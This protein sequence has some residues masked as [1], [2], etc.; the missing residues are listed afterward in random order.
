MQRI[1]ILMSD[2]GG[3]HRA[4][5]AAIASAIEFE[6]PGKYRVDLYDGLLSA[7]IFPFN[8]LD[9]IYFWIVTYAESLYGKIF[10]STNRSW[11]TPIILRLLHF[12]ISRRITEALRLYSPNLVISVHPLLTTVP[13]QILHSLYPSVPFVVV[14]TDLFNVHELWLDDE[15]DLFIVPN[16]ESR[17]EAIH[18]GVPAEK[19]RVSGLPIHL[20]F[21]QG[22]VQTKSDIRAKLGLDPTRTTVLLVGGGQGMGRLSDIAHQVAQSAL[23]IQ[24]VIIA[25]R[26]AALQ[27]K[28]S[29]AAWKIPVSVQGFV[30][31]MHDWMAA[32]DILITKAGPATI[33]EGMVAGLPILLSGFLPGQEEQN[34]TFVVREEIGAVCKNPAEIGQHLR[35]WLQEDRSALEKY[36]ARARELARPRAA[37]D[38]ASMVNELVVSRN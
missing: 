36:S 22:V 33:S 15:A 27:R 12:A 11:L 20:A 13:R 8:H 16:V 21:S 23:P 24:L 37:L 9:T 34:V 28:L 10:H 4:A 35:Q 30:T 17:D 2:T 38:I 7:A 31:N 5:A 32:S 1:L 14:V 3:G 19:I 18:A 25:G 6:F 29:S 26:N